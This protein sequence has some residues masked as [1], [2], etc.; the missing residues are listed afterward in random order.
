MHVIIFAFILWFYILFDL[1]YVTQSNTVILV[2]MGCAMP[3]IQADRVQA[4]INYTRQ[5]P[6]YTNVIWF[7]TGGVKHALTKSSTS[8]AQQMKAVIGDKNIVLDETA[9]NSAENFAHLRKWLVS[10]FPPSSFPKIVITT[11]EFHKNRASKIFSGIFA[12]SPFPQVE[13][14]LGKEACSHCWSDED[15]HIR[16]VE[17]DVYRAM[18]LMEF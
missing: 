5:L 8:E 1:V 17:V 13:W 9:T 7:L 3:E 16:N 10:S 6:K 18:L 15:I 4:A 12:S 2:I 11:S 14:N